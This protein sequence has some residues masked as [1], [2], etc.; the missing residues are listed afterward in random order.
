MTKKLYFLLLS[1]LTKRFN[2]EIKYRMLSVSKTKESGEVQKLN[3]Y[4]PLLPKI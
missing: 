1:P 3:I 2:E 4:A